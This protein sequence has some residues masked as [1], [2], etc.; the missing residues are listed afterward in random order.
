MLLSIFCFGL[1]LD[2]KIVIG[3]DGLRSVTENM[4]SFTGRR[5]SDALLIQIK[6]DCIRMQPKHPA[7]IYIFDS[8][9]QT[10]R[11]SASDVTVTFKINERCRS[12]VPV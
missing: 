10:K 11:F 8:G 2:H 6:P 5:H 12:C 1:S 9:L 3:K 4:Y 7:A